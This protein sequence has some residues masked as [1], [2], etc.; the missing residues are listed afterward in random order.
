MTTNTIMRAYSDLYNL[1]ST[2]TDRETEK[3]VR[4][5]GAAAQELLEEL[6][7][8]GEVFELALTRLNLKRTIDWAVARTKGEV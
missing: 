7:K 2:A 5:R 4:E 3:L 1:L 6:H 8:R